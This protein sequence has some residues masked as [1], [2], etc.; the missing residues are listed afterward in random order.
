MKKDERLIAELIFI[1]QKRQFNLTD[2]M[3]EFSIS[4]RTALRDIA[5][6]ENLGAPITVDKRRFGGYHLIN[7]N[8]LPPLYW[9]CF[10]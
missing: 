1:N 10:F 8:S 5:D 2:L 9:F 7:T 4:K 3:T 6:L